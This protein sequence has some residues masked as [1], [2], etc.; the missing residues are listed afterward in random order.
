MI[1][2]G[3]DREK[4][5]LVVRISGHL[6]IETMLRLDDF[7]SAFVDAEGPGHAILDFS[8]VS[9]ISLDRGRLARRA[10]QR[11]LAP[12]FERVLVA[13]TP[14]LMRLALHFRDSQRQAGHVAPLVART[15]EDAEALLGLGTLRPRPLTVALVEG[16]AST[17]AYDFPVHA[18]P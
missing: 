11:P 6:D 1:E 5:V 14:E 16:P 9:T 4:N 15:H 2:A 12:G 3:Y 7:C 8:E 13:E 18:P 17:D 10:A